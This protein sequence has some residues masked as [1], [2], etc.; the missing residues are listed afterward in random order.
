M[1]YNIKVY[2]V[3]PQRNARK[4]LTT[5]DIGAACPNN[6]GKND[7]V[8]LNYTYV[9]RSVQYCIKLIHGDTVYV[10]TKNIKNHIMDKFLK[11]KCIKCIYMHVISFDEYSSIVFSMSPYSFFDVDLKSVYRYYRQPFGNLSVRNAFSN[12]SRLGCAGFLIPPMS[13]LFCIIKLYKTIS[14][15]THFSVQ[16]GYTGPAGAYFIPH[17]V[18]YT[19]IVIV[20]FIL[21]CRRA[22]VQYNILTVMLR[23]GVCVYRLLLSNYKR[24]THTMCIYDESRDKAA[25]AAA[26]IRKRGGG[27]RKT[28]RVHLQRTVVGAAK[29]RRRNAGAGN[30]LAS[31]PPRRL[32]HPNYWAPANC[33]TP[34]PVVPVYDIVCSYGHPYNI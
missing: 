19:Y 14:H 23:S 17:Q 32:A 6:Y 34:G 24:V 27:G 4:T 26:M 29:K 7:Q 33:P 8:R 2:L 22:A 11:H 10:K 30:R 1:T 20:F 3:I 16:Q 9:L 12:G 18:S 31:R 15:P 21:G 25:A 28:R 13:V 5:A